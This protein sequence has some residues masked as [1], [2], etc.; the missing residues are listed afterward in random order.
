MKIFY[1]M[2][3]KYKRFREANYKL[4]KYLLPVKDHTMLDE[5]LTL[6]KGM[7]PI[8]IANLE[9]KMYEKD[10]EKV[11]E[12]V[13]GGEIFWCGDTDGQAT[14][15]KVALE[16]SKNTEYNGPVLFH[17]ID[18]LTPNRNLKEAENLLKTHGTWIDVFLGEGPYSF[19]EVKD[20]KV[21]GIREKIPVSNLASSGLYGFQN[22]KVFLDAY[23]VSTKDNNEKYISSVINASIAQGHSSFYTVNNEIIVLG[24]PKEY[25]NYLV[26]NKKKL[27]EQ[28]NV[29]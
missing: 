18:T 8:L 20:N 19:V 15:A 9:D 3:G 23:S 12:K 7:K 14:T 17:N 26:K 11:I 5:C 25:E 16:L 1:C 6:V 2:A 24:T 28:K 22:S 13:G 29:I 10:L 4:P 21:I 27:N